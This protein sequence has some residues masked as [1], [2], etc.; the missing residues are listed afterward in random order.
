MLVHP[1]RLQFMCGGVLV[2]DKVVE[3]EKGCLA[4]CDWRGGAEPTGRRTMTIALRLNY[5]QEQHVQLLYR[6]ST[7]RLFCI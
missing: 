1:L 6:I 2:L 5:A 7:S 4:S 3:F